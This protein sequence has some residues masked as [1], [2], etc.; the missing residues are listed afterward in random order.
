MERRFI[1]LLALLLT[2]D[3]VKSNVGFR[4]T[5]TRDGVEALDVGRAVSTNLAQLPVV[6]EGGPASC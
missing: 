6:S 3:V 5:S 2:T 4:A 1:I